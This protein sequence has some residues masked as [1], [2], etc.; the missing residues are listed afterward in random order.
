MDQ[1]SSSHQTPHS[2]PRRGDL[3][4]LLLAASLVWILAAAAPPEADP[5]EADPPPTE[6]PESRD[7]APPPKAESEDRTIVLSGPRRV[8]VGEPIS[9]SLRDAD[10]QEVLRSFAK[11]AKVNLIIDPSVQGTVT[12]ELRDVPWDQALYVICKT[13][14]LGIDVVGE[15]LWTLAPARELLDGD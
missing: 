5:P 9:L 4:L 7:A 11:L 1:P 14:R 12:L 6:A 3:H 8:W 15:N 13:H 2:H 10:L